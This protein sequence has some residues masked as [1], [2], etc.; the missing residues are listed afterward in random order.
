MKAN[1]ENWPQCEH[2]ELKHLPRKRKKQDKKILFNTLPNHLIQLMRNQDL[3]YLRNVYG[4][5]SPI[6]DVKMYLMNPK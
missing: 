3:D 1:L 5:Q 2:P 4:M 6:G